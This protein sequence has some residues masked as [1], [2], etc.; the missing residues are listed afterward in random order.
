MNE[1]IYEILDNSSSD[2]LIKVIKNKGNEFNQETVTYARQLLEERDIDVSNVPV[3]DSAVGVSDDYAKIQK[4]KFRKTFLKISGP[5]LLLG[6][7]ILFVTNLGYGRFSIMTLLNIILGSGLIYRYFMLS[8]EIKILEENLDK[9]KEASPAKEEFSLI[10]RLRTA[11][12]AAQK[13]NRLDLQHFLTAHIH[14]QN[15]EEV[16]QLYQTEYHRD[17]IE[18]IKK[19]SNEYSTIKEAL[20][21]L[22]DKGL[23]EARYPHKRIV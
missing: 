1:Q 8:K 18:E 2:D 11:I 6:S 23:V 12:V 5:V 19:V 22:I 16:T 4:L 15:L 9:P 21:P 13:G 20:Q 7:L 3:V 17:F 14:Q 10:T